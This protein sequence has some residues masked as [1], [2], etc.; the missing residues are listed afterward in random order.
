MSANGELSIRERKVLDWRA[1]QHDAMQALLATLVNIDSGSYN[2]AGV[3]RFAPLCF[4]PSNA[5]VSRSCRTPVVLTSF[6]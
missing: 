3:D 4:L 2:K 5:C 6:Q 1:E